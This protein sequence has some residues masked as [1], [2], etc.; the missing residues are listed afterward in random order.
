MYVCTY[1]CIYMQS[2]TNTHKHT[3]VHT[4]AA[5]R[6]QPKPSSAYIPVQRVTRTC[7]RRNHKAQTHTHAHMYI[8][9]HTQLDANSANLPLHTY[10][11]NALREPSN[12]EIANACARGDGLC[13]L[14]SC[15]LVTNGSNSNAS[16]SNGSHGSNSRG[17]NGSNGANSA[18]ANG[19]NGETVG[20]RVRALACD[21]LF[22]Q[23][24]VEARVCERNFT[25]V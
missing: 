9:T 16:N 17:L 13:A 14:C 22:H 15:T 24:C 1:I 12:G 5:W 25:C 4:H 11:S 7:Q 2:H 23:T 3:H 10:L 18:G 20:R 6:Q 19:A 21:H 8:Y